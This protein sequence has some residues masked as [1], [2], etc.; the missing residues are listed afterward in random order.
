[1][2]IFFLAAAVLSIVI[3]VAIIL[4]PD[5]QRARVLHQRRQG[6]LSTDGWFPRRGLFD[7][8]TIVAGTLVIAA[9]AMLVA[10]PL[11]LG[12]GIY[13]SE[14]ATP[15]VARLK[16]IIEILASIPS[17]V[18]GFFALTLLSPTSSSR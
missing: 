13:L 15:R 14:Y 3:S 4:S 10:A 7:I 1:M 8:T 6:S 9:V 2:R 17:V 11:G 12:A 5:R 16:P 18:L